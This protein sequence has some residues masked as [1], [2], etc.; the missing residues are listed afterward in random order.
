[1]IA[2]KIRIERAGEKYPPA[3][4]P[5]NFLY[6]VS[7]P[8]IEMI[9]WYYEKEG[10]QLIGYDDIDERTSIVQLEESLNGEYIKEVTITIGQSIKQQ[11]FRQYMFYHPSVAKNIGAP[12]GCNGKQ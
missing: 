1:M 8:T 4:R 6:P 9:G 2:D 12:Q 11:I 10:V 3:C 5:I 7:E